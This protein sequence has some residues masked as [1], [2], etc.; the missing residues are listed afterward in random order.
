MKKRYLA[1]IIIPLI[2]IVS[3]FFVINLTNRNKNIGYISDDSRQVALLKD[4][5]NDIFS[6]VLIN[7]ST[8]STDPSVHINFVTYNHY[9]ISQENILNDFLDFYALEKPELVY[10]ISNNFSL[11]DLKLTI[12]LVSQEE[13]PRTITYIYKL[14]PHKKDN[15]IKYKLIKKTESPKPDEVEG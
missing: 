15:T 12:T 2:F 8:F 10:K 6:E 3:F 4:I 13:T 7:K 5:Y 14:K 11:K 9:V 1:L